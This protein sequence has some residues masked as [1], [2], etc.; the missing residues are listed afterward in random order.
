MKE[1]NLKNDRPFDRRDVFI[2]AFRSEYPTLLKVS[3]A[4]L[5]FAIPAILVFLWTMLEIYMLGDLGDAAMLELYTIQTRMY[6]WLIPA[7]AIL[8]VGASGAF[9]V[10]RRLV[11]R[12]D[13]HFFKDFCRGIKQNAPQSICAGVLF[14]V[15]VGALSY[16]VNTLNLNV[17]LGSAYWIV[18]ILQAFLVAV[19][20]M[21]LMFQYCSIAVYSDGMFKI[22]K[23]SF[24]LVWMSLPRTTLILLAALAPILLLLTFNSVYWIYLVVMIFMALV[25]FAYGI[26]LFTLHAHNVFDRFINKNNFPQIYKKGLYHEGTDIDV[27]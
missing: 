2:G 24:F 14:S 20:V 1:N 22:V 21:L 9:Y 4:M 23:N 25:G 15:F 10:M 11:W 18:V 17:K 7:F 3:L 19:A 26:L 16:T 12:E 27:D 5:V 8:S 13:L 6:L